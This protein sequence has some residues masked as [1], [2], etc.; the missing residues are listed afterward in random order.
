M[1]APQV[2]TSQNFGSL[3]LHRRMRYAMLLDQ[4]LILVSARMASGPNTRV[5]SSFR[6]VVVQNCTSSPVRYRSEILQD[7]VNEAQ[8][9]HPVFECEISVLGHCTINRGQQGV[10]LKRLYVMQNVTQNDEVEGGWLI[11]GD[12]IDRPLRKGD[13][14]SI[15]EKAGRSSR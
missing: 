6:V 14:G 3:L 11:T 5:R 15:P 13:A 2:Y 7:P 9:G 8:R 4:G 1:I 10:A 12:I